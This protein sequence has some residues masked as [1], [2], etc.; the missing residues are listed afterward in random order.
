MNAEQAVQSLLNDHHWSR[1]S[2]EMCTRARFKCEYCGRDYLSSSDTHLY[3]FETDHVIPRS[4]GGT[5]DFENLALACI[6]CNRI[7]R[8]TVP[9]PDLVGQSRAELV[10]AARS[11]IERLRK[12][13]D[14][15]LAAVRSLLDQ[16]R[17][18][19]DVQ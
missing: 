8:H 2:L 1:V 5:D 4:K 13:N 10:A 18:G 14:E 9:N 15:R 17:I 11:Y 6:P 16:L 19:G 7:K 12:R 3:G